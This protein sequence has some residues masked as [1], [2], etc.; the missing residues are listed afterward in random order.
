MAIPISQIPQYVPNL[1]MSLAKNLRFVD[2]N[3]NLVTRQLPTDYINNIGGSLS[4]QI[5]NINAILSSLQTVNTSI[6]NIQTQVNQILTSGAIAIPNVSPGCLTSGGVL[7]IQ[8]VTSLLVSNACGYNQVLG[9]TSALFQA[10]AAQPTNLNS[11]S[12]FSIPKGVMASLPG[13]KSQPFTVSDTINNEWIAYGDA[14]TGIA[15]ALAAVTPSCNQVVVNYLATLNNGMSFNLYLSGYAFYPTGF[16]N[17]GSTL[18]IADNQ[19]GIYQVGLDPTAASVNPNPLVFG[20]SGS[21]LSPTSPTY[22]LT[23][24]SNVTNSALGLTCQK[25]SIQTINNATSTSELYDIGNYTLLT[26]GSALTIIS[27][28]SYTPRFVAITPKNTFTSSILYGQ[29]YTA[30][31]TYIAGGAVLNLAGSAN[32]TF[33]LDWI[34]HR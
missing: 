16:V 8:T 1:P 10:V 27:G 32:G 19:G 24:N 2:Y 18:T 29:N 12:A 3:S 15:Q 13:W 5:D 21:A 23:L 31:L 25:V 34:A 14:R 30:Y 7:P 20:T 17:N 22:T 9:T 28:L 33:N 26:S 11:L 4:I 6:A